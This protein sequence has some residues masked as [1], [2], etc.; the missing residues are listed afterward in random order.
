MNNWVTRNKH[1]RVQ[2]KNKNKK[3]KK[4]KT[5]SYSPT[6]KRSGTK[7][8]TL[9]YHQNYQTRSSR[10]FDFEFS[11]NQISRKLILP[12]LT[13]SKHWNNQLGLLLP[14]NIVLNTS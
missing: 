14:Y 11:K 10:I 3:K 12:Y 5:I 6:K 9:K 13:M 8:E 2:K 1:K 4:D 7:T